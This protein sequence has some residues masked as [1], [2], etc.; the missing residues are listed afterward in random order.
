MDERQVFIPLWNGMPSD[1]F[2]DT[3]EERERERGR[4]GGREREREREICSSI[5]ALQN[6][7]S[8]IT[9]SRGKTICAGV[10]HTPLFET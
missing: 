3:S 5:S 9:L 4:E 2:P 1:P 7:I 10:C 8:F 6:G